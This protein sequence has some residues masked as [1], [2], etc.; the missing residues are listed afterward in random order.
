MIPEINFTFSS[1][2]LKQGE[3]KSRKSGNVN[4]KYNTSEV[5][6]LLHEYNLERVHQINEDLSI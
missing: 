6:L 2:I 4:Q 5:S 3:I 1:D